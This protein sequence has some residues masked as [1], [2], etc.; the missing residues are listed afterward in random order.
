MI[1][2]L[3]CNSKKYFDKLLLNDKYK[4]SNYLKFNI[5]FYF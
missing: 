2:L 5:I 3:T 1:F 4:F